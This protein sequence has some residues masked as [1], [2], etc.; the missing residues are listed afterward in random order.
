M[1]ALHGQGW[2]IS[3]HLTDQLSPPEEEEPSVEDD[4][5]LSPD[6]D[7]SPAALDESVLDVDASPSLGWVAS[8]GCAVSGAWDG[9][10]V[11]TGM[12]ETVG[13]GVGSGV[14]AAV[15]LGAGVDV[16]GAAV[17]WGA[18]DDDSDN[19]TC[20][21]PACTATAP[22]AT[23]AIMMSMVWIFANSRCFIGE[24]LVFVVGY[25]SLHSAN[26]RKSQQSRKRIRSTFLH[27]DRIVFP[28]SSDILV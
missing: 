8:L 23:P 6:C 24:L 3:V 2:A 25:H 13:W 17:D 28:S 27:Q 18:E 20:C 7:P 14:G 19:G 9:A 22:N 21:R 11:A 4:A 1:P 12:I 16:A 26:T 10:G 5:E 15:A